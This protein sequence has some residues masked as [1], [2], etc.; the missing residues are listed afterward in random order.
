VKLSRIF[1]SSLDTPESRGR[2]RIERDGPPGSDPDRALGAHA[3]PAVLA[4]RLCEGLPQPPVGVLDPAAGD[5][6]LLLAAWRA[7]GSTDGAAARLFGFELDPERCR[8]ARA[9]L[10]REIGG[11]AGERAAEHLV[12]ADALDPAVLWPPATAVVANPP[13]VSFSGR[14]SAGT[15]GAAGARPALPRPGGW[16]SLHGAFLERIAAHVAQHRTRARVVFPAALADAPRYGPVRE[17]ITRHAVPTEPWIELG[18]AAFPGVVEPAL[19]LGL[20]PRGRGAGG[21]GSP[22]PWSLLDPRDR[23]WTERLAGFPPLP[24]AAYGDPGVHTGNAAAELI[25]RGPP[26]PGTAPLRE[27]RDLAAF[28]LRPARAYLRLDLPRLPGRRFRVGPPERYARV[29]ILVRQTADRPIAALH[30]DPGPFRNSL[31]ACAPPEGLDPRFV[32]A[33][34]NSDLAAAWHRARFR[35]ARQ[36]AFPQVKVHH[37]RS[38]PFPLVERAAD[39]SLHDA[40][41]RAVD[42]RRAGWRAECERLLREATGLAEEPWSERVDALAGRRA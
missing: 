3:T 21:P 32:L 11:A 42:E 16:P 6:E 14:R 35:D 34:L 12:C 27:G 8:R 24:P 28:E 2:P 17:R 41:V 7:A 29:P 33:V 20:A 38:L 10:R 30:V 31:L 9:R 40:V 19:A 37:L 25:G 39:P 15:A 26:P 22:A 4:A 13:W 36:R 1:D 23:A 5:G 18:E